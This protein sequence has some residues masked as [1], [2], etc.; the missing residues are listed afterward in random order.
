MN[1]SLK[2]KQNEGAW[3]WFAKIIF[4]F[5]I[6]IILGV[7]FVVNHI[8]APGGLLSYA[9]VI[10]YY[11]NPIIP[12]MEVAFLIFVIS[13]CLLGLRSILLDLNPTPK[14]LNIFNWFFILVGIVATSYGTWLV[15]ELVSRGLSASG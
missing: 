5:L 2:P 10:K 6:L 13:H 7:H 3:L 12:I 11:T 14:I 9:D 1:A 15:F 8:L 4:S